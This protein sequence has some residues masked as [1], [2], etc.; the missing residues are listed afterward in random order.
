[1]TSL[2]GCLGGLGLAG[3][4]ALGMHEPFVFPSLGPTL[5]VAF[6]TPFDPSASPRNTLLGHGVGL[7]AGYLCLL[8]FGL[9][10]EPLHTVPALTAARAAAAVLSL[11][12]TEL[13]LRL[14]RAA[15]APA[16]A[17]TLIVSLGILHRPSQLAAM[18]GAVLLV[19][20]FAWSLN[21]LVG[22]QVPVWRASPPGANRRQA[23]PSAPR[24]S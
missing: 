24:R 21:R 1:M 9:G 3:L 13:G 15:H 10:N 20:V 12:L 4:L 6:D 7:T 8:V 16:G 2:L 5:M 23:T 17:T 22:R 19:T 11:A 18:A 14:L